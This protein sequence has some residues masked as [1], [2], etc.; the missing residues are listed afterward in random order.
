MKKLLATI[1]ALVMALSFCILG[2]AAEVVYVAKIGEAKYESL[3]E[4]V[5][6]AK[7]GKVITLLKNIDNLDTINIDNGAKVVIDLG[8][9]TLTF[10]PNNML[11]IEGGSLDLRGSGTVKSSQSGRD[12]LST[13]YLYGNSTQDVADYSVVTIGKDVII[14]NEGSYGL[15]VGHKANNVA[16]GAKLVLSGKVKATYG[17]TVNG[18]IKATSGNI[19]EITITETGSIESTTAS[20]SGALYAAGYAKYNVAGTLI[21]LEMGV[22][23]RAGILNIS[24][25]A[26]IT[27]TGPF[28]DPAPNGNGSTTR[29]VAVA[30][31]QHTTNLPITVNIYGGTIKATGT[32]GKSLYEIDTVKNEA[33]ENVAKDVQ[34]NVFGGNFQQEVYSTNEKVSISGGTFSNRVDPTYLADGLKYEVCAGGKY[35][36]YSDFD[37]AAEAAKADSSGRI[38]KIGTD[39]EGDVPFHI[40]YADGT[41]VKPALR[42]SKDNFELPT[43]TRSGYT[44]KGWKIALHEGEQIPGFTGTYTSEQVKGIVFAEAAT[45][46]GANN[47]FSDGAYLTAVWSSNS[48]YY[49]APTTTDTKTDSP[50]T[51]DAGVGIYAVTALLSVTGMAWA[52]KKRH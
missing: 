27:A 47:R 50:K 5:N 4:A 17:F 42:M 15:G 10:K 36:Y 3:Q 24:D 8:G 48:Y 34:V 40:D 26:N 9:H 2:W 32:N 13:I 51:F 29:G 1:L 30:V 25:T 12:Y 43:P 16:Y 20:D 22:E 41:G 35:S 21:G 52:G 33:K 6:A 18:Q 28:N 14:E 44:F 31:S 39:D 23:I 45:D 37:S 19:P 7:D 38:T 46:G 11:K 49:Y